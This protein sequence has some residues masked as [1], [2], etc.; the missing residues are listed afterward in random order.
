MLNRSK[1]AVVEVSA[2]DEQTASN[3]I[4]YAAAEGGA[5]SIEYIGAN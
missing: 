5:S 4:R 1:V 2:G 3:V